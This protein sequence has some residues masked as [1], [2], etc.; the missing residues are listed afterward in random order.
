VVG[1]EEEK[2]FAA[3]YQLSE[4][5]DDFFDINDQGIKVIN[6]TSIIRYGVLNQYGKL[7]VLLISLI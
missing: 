6:I 5:I 1:N 7:T 3:I 4:L 2:K